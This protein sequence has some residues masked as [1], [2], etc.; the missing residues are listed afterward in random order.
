[1]TAHATRSSPSRTPLVLGTLLLLTL[2]LRVPTTAV[3]PVLPAIAADTQLT[4][5]LL[6]LLTT[7]PLLCFVLV[8]P[9]VPVLHRR[10][11][12]TR[13][14]GIALLGAAAGAFLRTLPGTVMLAGGTLVLGVFVAIASVLAPAVVREVG[15]RKP[16]FVTALY[17][18][19]LS[20]GPAMAAGL[21]VPIGG[22]L[23]SPWRA[24]LAV[25]GLVPLLGLACWLLQHR[26]RGSG[27]G[28]PDTATATEAADSATAGPE[29]TAGLEQTPGPEP[30]AGLGAVLREGSAWLIT[31]Y[32]SL[33]SLAFYTTTT[34][35][36]SVLIAGGASNTAAGAIT[37][38]TGI[39]AIPASFVVPVLSERPSAARVLRIAAPVPVALGL[40]L[41]AVAPGLDLLA[42]ALLG[43]GQG[44]SVGVAY[45][46][47]VTF[48]RSTPHAAALSSMSQTVGVTLAG[49][50]PVGFG[51]LQETTGA[52][53]VPLAVFTLIALGQSL[54]GLLLRPRGREPVR[55]V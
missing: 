23:D 46:L 22:A 41:L 39:V 32:L 4:P 3:G 33:T 6:S 2:T 37:A 10:L 31:A 45:T 5:T 42:A 53:Q 34:W 48:A 18:A 12:L 25:W 55:P 50:G 17:T 36:P 43:L 54:V 1:M 26:R 49:I 40:G 47:I 19:G 13:V 21:T 27:P 35:L 52:W 8:A 24:P 11:G 30:T 28:A 16:A 29:P 9:I 7:G 44:A 14:I 51:L 15:A 38:V 20:I